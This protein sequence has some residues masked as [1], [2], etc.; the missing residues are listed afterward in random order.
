VGAYPRLSSDRRRCFHYRGFRIEKAQ[1]GWAIWRGNGEVGWASTK[2][3]AKQ[4]VDAL[5][6]GPDQ[7]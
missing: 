1:A 4:S 7:D 3:R 5:I 6:D 2:L